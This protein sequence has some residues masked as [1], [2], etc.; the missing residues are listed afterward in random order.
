[1]TVLQGT[2]IILFCEIF[3]G[4]A[5]RFRTQHLKQLLF[6]VMSFFLMTLHRVT[7]EIDIRY[8]NPV[9]NNA[10][11]RSSSIGMDPVFRD[12]NAPAPTLDF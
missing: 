10:L 7:A 6:Y 5:W 9:S 12:R 4:I 11:I 1:M 8:P 2:P 3:P